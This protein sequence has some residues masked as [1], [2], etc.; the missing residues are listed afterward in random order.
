VLT[1]P[2]II[3]T[4]NFK[5]MKSVIVSALLISQVAAFSTLFGRPHLATSGAICT[6][7]S[8]KDAEHSFRPAPLFMGRAA[9]VRAKTKGKTDDRKAKTNASF[10]KRIIMA[11]K[12]GGSPDP[13]ANR[14]LADVIKQAKSNNV[15][16]DVSQSDFV[17]C[18]A[19]HF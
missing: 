12:Q 13:N 19:D 17:S 6:H 3:S 18:V 16:A 14:S 5:K 1:V 11:V 2:E 15:P 7:E 4:I 8:Q 10:G 9:A